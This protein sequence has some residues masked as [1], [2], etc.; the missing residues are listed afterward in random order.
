MV[1]LSWCYQ[2]IL[3]CSRMS[4]GSCFLMYVWLYT[5]LSCAARPPCT[6]PLS[7]SRNLPHGRPAVLYRTKYSILHHSDYISGYSEV[8]SMPLWTSYTV[9]RQVSLTVNRGVSF[10]LTHHHETDVF[11]QTCVPLL[12]V[13]FQRRTG[14]NTIWNAQIR[15]WTLNVWVRAV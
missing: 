1:S 6:V 15:T 12:Q 8:L 13:G 7:D 3:K 9:S 11:S 10:S 5:Y 2:T 4:T 14:R